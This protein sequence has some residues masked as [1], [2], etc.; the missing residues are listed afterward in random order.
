[1]NFWRLVSAARDFFVT[2]TSGRVGFWGAVI[3]FGVA[4]W[5]AVDAVSNMDFIA[6]HWQ[7]I[8]SFMQTWGFF[9]GLV[10]ADLLIAK[11]VYDTSGQSLP[12]PQPTSRVTDAT[13]K[14][15][16][17]VEFTLPSKWEP[18]F[19]FKNLGLDEETREVLAEEVNVRVVAKRR[20]QDVRFE[21]AVRERRHNQ[22]ETLASIGSERFAGVVPQGLDQTFV[23]MRRTFSMINAVRKDLNRDNAEIHEQMRADREVIFFPENPAQFAG[24]IGHAYHV[25]I[26]VHHD[27]GPP[28]EARFMLT[29]DEKRVPV[30]TKLT[31]RQNIEPITVG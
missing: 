31:N 20:M 8:T 22:L 7:A 23:I 9:A 3:L 14:N 29:L 5:K 30:I 24:L 18:G 21:I 2:V 27:D 12:L 15:E 10:V 19:R 13:A 4:A 16:P 25:H 11:A 26:A 28:D 6:Q 17:A 1:M